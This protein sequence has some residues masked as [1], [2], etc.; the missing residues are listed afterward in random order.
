MRHALD[1]RDDRTQNKYE[2][3]CDEYLGEIQQPIRAEQLLHAFHN[4]LVKNPYHLESGT[5][6]SLVSEY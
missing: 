4:K 6:F 3:E 1:R 2:R 5:Q